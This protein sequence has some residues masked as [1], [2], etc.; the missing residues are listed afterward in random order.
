M[1]PSQLLSEA[2]SSLATA[3]Q[4]WNTA[5]SVIAA[6]AG[7]I[8]SP[9]PGCDSASVAQVEPLLQVLSIAKTAGAQAA[10]AAAALSSSCGGAG[11]A[12]VAQAQAASKAAAVPGDWSSESGPSTGLDT[13]SGSDT[14]NC[15]DS[16]WVGSVGN[17][18]GS[19]LAAVKAAQSVATACGA[20]STSSGVAHVQGRNLTPNPKASR[21]PASFS[22]PLAPLTV[23]SQQAPAPFRD[24]TQ[25]FGGLP[26]GAQDASIAGGVA[27]GVFTGAI[28]GVVIGLIADAPWSGA[29]GGATIG[30]ILGGIVAYGNTTTSST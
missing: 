20:L 16:S 17:R 18:L 24:A 1:T 19:A 4:L 14:A 22:P 15:I 21:G 30:G 26:T 13:T 10:Q 28:V 6:N 23:L 11:A 12:Y 29:V 7:D 3:N 5:N 9:A 27:G 8:Q 25:Q 2:T